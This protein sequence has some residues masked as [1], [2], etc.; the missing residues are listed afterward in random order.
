LCQAITVTSGG[1]L[2][3]M[4]ANIVRL[5]DK[6]D[7]AEAKRQIVQ[8]S[9]YIAQDDLVTLR[10]VLADALVARAFKTISRLG[11]RGPENACSV[12]RIRLI[13]EAVAELDTAES[14]AR[15]PSVGSAIA[16][17]KGEIYDISGFPLD[18]FGW[19]TVAVRRNPDN[20]H[21]RLQLMKSR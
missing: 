9:S 17:R 18:A 21:A 13:H 3:F 8:W 10:R 2:R 20:L 5:V 14:I 11:L 16:M 4:E 1:N 6:G 19:Y 15:N 12:D 7:V